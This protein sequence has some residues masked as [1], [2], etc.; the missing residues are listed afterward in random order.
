MEKILMVADCVVTEALYRKYFPEAFEKH[1][2]ELVEDMKGYTTID[3][4]KLMLGTE[5]Q[6]AEA[7]DANPEI[8]EKIKD[9]TILIVHMSVINSQVLNA[10]K[11]LKTIFVCRGG[12]DNLNMKLA[13]EKGIQV[14]NAASRSADAVADYTV[15]MMIAETKNMIRAAISLANGKWEKEFS[16]FGHHHNL[17]RLVVGIIGFGEIGKRVAKR[18]KGF[19]CRVL[20]HD[21]YLS[22]D[23]VRERGGVPVTLKQLLTEADIV[24]IH[25]RLSESTRN[26]IGKAELDTMKKTAYLVNT[27]RSG[28][29]DQDALADALRERKIMGAAL[30]VFDIEP[31]PADSKFRKLDNVSLTPHMAGV[32]CDTVDIGVE[33]MGEAFLKHI[34]RA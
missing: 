20:V 27:A 18:L 22:D 4:Q 7:F 11:N 30:D 28:L 8:V 5:Q 19:E 34:N 25:L 13:K 17:G 3:F 12:C 16:N 21:P 10:A 1:E 24:T 9:A 33:L 15:A 14:L 29:V 6:G 31:L 26:F 32:S 23:E 2:V